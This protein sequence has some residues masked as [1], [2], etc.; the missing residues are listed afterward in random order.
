M[1]ESIFLAIFSLSL[2][3]ILSAFFPKYVIGHLKWL[4]KIKFKICPKKFDKH[5]QI[6]LRVFVCSFV[7]IRTI[8]ARSTEHT[9]SAVLY[10]LNVFVPCRAPAA[11]VPVGWCCAE[12]SS[13]GAAQLPFMRPQPRDLGAGTGRPGGRQGRG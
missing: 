1:N 11:T 7:Y 5:S 10:L 9:T 8:T 12:P 13:L 3:L 2:R 4:N 6:T